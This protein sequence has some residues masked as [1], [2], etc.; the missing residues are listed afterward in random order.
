M[1]G[2]NEKV[3]TGCKIPKP[4]EEF[5]VLN[6]AKDGRNHRCAV[7]VKDYKTKHQVGLRANR[8]AWQRNNREDAIKHYGGKCACCGETTYEFLAIDH[9][10]GGKKHRAKIKVNIAYWLKKNGFPK[11][12]RILCHNCNMAKDR[13]GYCPHEPVI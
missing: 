11:G 2:K 10:G 4:V 7:C 8:R 1:I 3:C 9:V 6:V 12:F 13:Y 5:Y